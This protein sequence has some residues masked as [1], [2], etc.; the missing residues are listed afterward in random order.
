M[1]PRTSLV[2]AFIVGCIVLF[3]PS[4]MAGSI[5]LAWNTSSGA[6]GYRVH[7]GTSTGQ[8]TSSVDVGNVTQTTLASLADC[9]TSF[10]AVSAY[11][12]A[13]ESGFSGEVSSWPR[14]GLTT[15]N[16]LAALQGSQFTLSLSGSNFQPGSTLEIDNPNVLLNGT[17]V[18][19]CNQVQAVATVE[20]T[21]EG[22]RAAEV[23]RF[24]LTV[25]GPTGLAG[26][27]AQAF[28]VKIDPS[29]FDVDGRD[30]PSQGRLDGRDVIW[31]SRFFG[32][33]EGDVIYQPDSDFNGDG[34]VD[35]QDLSFLASNLGLCWS[36][37]AWAMSA[38]PASL[39]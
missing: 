34:W 9:N 8:Y 28:E 5:D 16:P 35:G 6:S 23:G 10:F 4:L 19:S 24:G 20:P 29:R 37:T 25:T 14:P 21:I 7:F 22:V 27:K 17:T 30:G 1:F 33:R 2:L 39:Q 31:L 3:S 32:S 38:C 12:A 11:N 36:G 13:G 15:T 26:S 18:V